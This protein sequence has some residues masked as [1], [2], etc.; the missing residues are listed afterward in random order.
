MYPPER[1]PYDWVAAEQEA[2][3][4]ECDDPANRG[5]PD[6]LRARRTNAMAALTHLRVLESGR[7]DPTRV[8][9]LIQNLH[10]LIRGACGSYRRAPS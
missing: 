2:I 7:T 5:H 10:R 6:G 9:E 4:R 3:I 1:S 8:V